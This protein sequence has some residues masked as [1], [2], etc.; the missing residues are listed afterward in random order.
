MFLMAVGLLFGMWALYSGWKFYGTIDW[1]EPP[2]PS[3]DLKAMH[4]KQAELQHIQELL[5]EAAAQGKIS[6]QVVD[7]INR[8]CDNEVDQMHA[9]ETAWK[10]RRT[11]QPPA[12]KSSV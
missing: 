7:E 3:P 9:V 12:S 11:K 2:E 4:K 8:Y 1:N 10:Q 6:R 5:A